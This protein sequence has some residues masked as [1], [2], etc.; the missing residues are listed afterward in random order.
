[1]SLAVWLLVVG[2]N[3]TKWRAQAGASAAVR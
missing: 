1:L 3:E 2:V